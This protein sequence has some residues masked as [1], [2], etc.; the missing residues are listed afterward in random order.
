[1]LPV[2]IWILI[3]FSLFEIAPVP[4]QKV[5]VSPDKY[6]ATLQF[7]GE[8]NFDKGER[9]FPVAFNFNLFQD[10]NGDG[11][12]DTEDNLEN[13]IPYAIGFQIT[14][15]GRSCFKNRGPND[16]RPAVYFHYVSIGEYTVYE[17]CLY[18]ADNDWINNHEHDWEKYFVY[19]KNGVPSY[20]KISRH[21]SFDKYEWKTIPKDSLH[22]LLS[23][24]RGSHAM[25]V[26]A[27]DGVVISYEGKISAH[28]GKLNEGDGKIIPWIIYCNDSNV[29]GAIQ[30]VAKPDIFYY[31]DPVYGG[32]K[33]EFKEPRNAPWKRKE[34]DEP[35]DVK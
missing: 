10:A 22:L 19:E 24:N 34:W 17:Y 11:K 23:V 7:D 5:Q 3:A 13:L 32:R 2:G 4:V 9:C 27:E 35:V 29:T 21:N 1:M 15:A 25:K 20:V 26:A 30:Y 16:Q 28:A 31:G 33:K 8:D 18:Y 12:I 14:G 6:L